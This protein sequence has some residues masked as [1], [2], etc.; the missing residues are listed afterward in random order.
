M[1]FHLFGPRLDAHIRKA[2][3]Y[4]AEANLARLEHQVAAE[5]HAALA[6]MYTERAARLEAEID[7]AMRPR[8][9]A[10]APAAEEAPEDN[11]RG[12][13]EPVL[14]PVPPARGHG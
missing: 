14:Y 6:R 11:R 4:L 2:R 5:H 13:A 3:E 9:F 1:S 10:G 7:A 8:L 12:G